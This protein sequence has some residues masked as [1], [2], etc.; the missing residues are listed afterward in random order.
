MDANLVGYLLN[1][2]GEEEHAE[3]AALLERDPEARARLEKLRSL[4]EPLAADRQPETVPADL[5][6]KTLARVAEYQG[7]AAAS[8]MKPPPPP[9]LSPAPLLISG[10]FPVFKP[11]WLRLD[12][13]VAA[14]LLLTFLGVGL[15]ALLHLRGQREA[16]LTCQN[17]LRQF[18][19]ALKGYHDVHGTFPNVQAEAE[20]RN[21]AGLVV[22]LLADRGTLDPAAVGC[23][24]NI[25]PKARPLPLA[26]VRNLPEDEFLSHAPAML[27]CYAY[28]LGYLD[29]D[30]Y[31]PAQIDPDLQ[32]NSMLPLM[33]DAPP[34]LTMI[35]NSTNHG[36]GG[37]NVLFQDGRVQFTTQRQIGVN[38]DDI[39]LNQAG[40]VAA[41]L[42]K[43][44]TV[45]GHSASRPLPPAAK[46]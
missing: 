25:L 15:P 28:S 19:L 17:S 43:H 41:G 22:P 34:H 18:Y 12:A 42:G 5:F 23:P 30:K 39:F 31:Y 20:P 44:D 32:L 46:K 24:G 26:Q 9:S 3:T 45:L 1:G 6:Y 29:Q 38:R 16:T 10:R 35:G 2:L 33:A 11:R 14:C 21:V 36:G 40:Q 27:S 4:L 7:Q 37:Q 8:T 13:L